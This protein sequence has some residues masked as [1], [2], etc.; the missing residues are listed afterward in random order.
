MQPFSSNLSKA[1]SYNF[2]G[3]LRAA[4]TALEDATVPRASAEV[5]SVHVL[6]QGV[7]VIQMYAGIVGSGI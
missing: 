4:R 2:L 5:D 1:S 6:R 3:V 7:N